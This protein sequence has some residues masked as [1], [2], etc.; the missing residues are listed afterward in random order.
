MGFKKIFFLFFFAARLS[1]RK[2]WKCTFQFNNAILKCLPR[3]SRKKHAPAV[4]IFSRGRFFGKNF[5]ELQVVPHDPFGK[6]GRKRRT[7][8]NGMP[9]LRMVKRKRKLSS[10]SS[11]R[12]KICR[13][14]FFLLSAIAASTSRHRLL[15]RHGNHRSRLLTAICRERALLLLRFDL[16]CML[17]RA[18]PA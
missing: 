5:H 9:F 3:A 15:Q 7:A 10:S 14:S 17:I 11:V 13:I 16:A 6:D 8:K 18:R 4:A 2:I 1:M 12:V